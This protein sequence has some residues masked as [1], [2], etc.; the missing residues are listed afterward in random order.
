MGIV[1]LLF[2]FLASV[3]A[4]PLQGH[5]RLRGRRIQE[6]SLLP[7][8]YETVKD[9]ASEAFHKSELVFG[10]HKS[11]PGLLPM[12]SL[13]LYS[14]HDK[15]GM[16]FRCGGTLI[17]PT[18][19]LTAAHCTINMTAPSNV[20]LGGVSLEYNSTTTQ[21]RAIHTVHIHPEYNDNDR[22]HH[23]DI[24]IIEFSPA[25]QF[26]NNIKLANI[27]KNDDN[28]IKTAPWAVVSGFG[29]MNFTKTARGTE[30]VRSPDL[31]YA[32][33]TIY[34]ATYCNDFKVWNGALNANEICAGAQGKGV[35]PGDSGGPIQVVDNHTTY[36]VGVASYATHLPYYMQNRQDLLP[37]VFMRVSHYCD[38]IS[39]I[40][41]GAFKCQ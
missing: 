40:T 15:P 19:I 5:D 2:C 3:A 33:V 38:Y 23:N 13:I 17:S 34:N 16:I 11:R 41:S 8:S 10:G 29:T 35:G 7:V 28:L 6:P 22:N 4:L 30:I 36:Q 12:Q 27:L 9:M 20:M 14:S 32:D 21:W 26:N 31:L 25:V 24:S 37:S 18:H 39:D 1:L